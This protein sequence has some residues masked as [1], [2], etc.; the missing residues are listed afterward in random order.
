MDEALLNNHLHKIHL[1]S[2]LGSIYKELLIES[3][4]ITHFKV[5]QSVTDEL[6]QA[7]CFIVLLSGRLLINGNA[8]VGDG[9]FSIIDGRLRTNWISV[10][11]CI[12][13]ILKV[14]T[15]ERLLPASVAKIVLED[16]KK[17]KRLNMPGLKKPSV[18]LKPFISAFRS[19]TTELRLLKGD[20]LGMKENYSYVLIEGCVQVRGKTGIHCYLVGPCVLPRYLCCNQT[21]TLT[22]RSDTIVL[23]EVRSKGKLYSIFLNEDMLLSLTLHS[24]NQGDCDG[25]DDLKRDEGPRDIQNQHFES[26]KG[27]LEFGRIAHLKPEES[28]KG[29][30]EIV[31]V[32]EGSLHFTIQ[33]GATRVVFKGQMFSLSASSLVKACKPSIIVIFNDSWKDHLSTLFETVEPSTK[34]H[35][36]IVADCLKGVS[37]FSSLS[38]EELSGLAIYCTRETYLCGQTLPLKRDDVMILVKGM[39]QMEQGDIV[40]KIINQG[41]I[42]GIPATLTQT[43]FIMKAVRD[44]EV[45]II[46][47]AGL[48]YIGSHYDSIKMRLDMIIESSMVMPLSLKDRSSS[49]VSRKHEEKGTTKETM[50]PF[51]L[52][53]VANEIIFDLLELRDQSNCR[54]VSHSWNMFL[55]RRLKI[56]DLNASGFRYQLTK[57]SVLVRRAG[58]YLKSCDLT[59]STAHLGNIIMLVQNCKNLNTLKVSC[60]SQYMNEVAVNLIVSHM[61]SLREVC[62]SGSMKLRGNLFHSCSWR[63]LQ[64]IQI[65]KWHGTLEDWI[66]CMDSFVKAC[67]LVQEI[68]FVGLSSFT[69]E[70]IKLL[71][72]GCK[73]I[74][75]L[76]LSGCLYITDTGVNHIAKELLNLE[77]LE[78]SFAPL[79]TSAGFQGFS[80]SSIILKKLNLLGCSAI[81]DTVLLFMRPVI[82]ELTELNLK[83]CFKVTPRALQLIRMNCKH[84]KQ[85]SSSTKNDELSTTK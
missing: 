45:V 36:I 66:K 67:P 43:N 38:D 34:I 47:S 25:K 78:L 3:F 24:H 55:S 74:R 27:I 62:F 33:D 84:L 52:P 8:T 6:P 69:D 18:I 15:I 82:T 19:I 73:Y 61:P 39:I 42:F 75:I 49:K 13:S 17:I 29:C 1:F 77:S 12:V 10:S 79:I 5:N 71:V 76:K 9:Y 4:E 65:T 37:L 56:E 70:C 80:K 30:D 7:D 14:D 44:F 54:L 83:Y 32:I 57:F 26:L 23:L 28:I 63:S 46:S 40:L 81:D 60:S 31:C 35:E 48:D 21:I 72:S 41:G 16:I 53:I 51:E 20:K 85:L 2:K 22:T 68:R 59:Y 11:S 64:S 50:L 58:N